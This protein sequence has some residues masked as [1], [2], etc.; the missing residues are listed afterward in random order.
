MIVRK[1]LFLMIIGLALFEL[2]F[3]AQPGG[4]KVWFVDSLIKVFPADRPGTHGLAVPEIWGAR[5]QHVSL[6]LAIRAPRP[7]ARVTAGVAG[8]ES[9]GGRR[10]SS[11]SVHPVGYVVV[12]SHTPDAPREELVGEA[13]GW[14]PD[15]LLDFPLEMEGGRTY[16][17]WITVHVPEDATPGLYRGTVEARA[18]KIVVTRSPFRLRVIAASVPEKRSLKL[19]NWFSLD[20]KVS[21]QFYG[22]RAFTPEWWTLVENVGRVLAE[23]RQ[24][25]ILTP[26]MELVQPRV[27]A[28]SLRYDFQNFDRWVEAFQRAGAI[29]LIEGSHLLDRAGSYDSPL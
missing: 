21:R 1:G 15:P 7:L 28:E 2:A 19:T 18:G 4:V 12:G 26:L 8:L 24:D 3:A 29:G 5:N 22:V 20:D 13:P 14:Y 25:V 9:P 16:P 23:H 6:Q 10:I 17:L 27:E 11:V